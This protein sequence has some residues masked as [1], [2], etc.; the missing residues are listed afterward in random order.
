MF[1]FP[2]SPSPFP[3][4]L[5]P[6]SYNAN[7]LSSILLKSSMKDSFLVVFVLNVPIS[8]SKAFPPSNTFDFPLSFA[9][10]LCYLVN[11]LETPQQHPQLLTFLD[12]M[13]MSTLQKQLIFV[14]LEPPLWVDWVFHF[15]F[16][17]SSF[18]CLTKLHFLL[19]L[20]W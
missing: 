5:S 17:R 10:M 9:W 12:L 16:L 15:C 14:L 3:L 2:W 19:Y 8:S 11:G 20:A 18:Q 4:P 1:P 7:F 13:T 6:F